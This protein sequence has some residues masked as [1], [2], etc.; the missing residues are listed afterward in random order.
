MSKHASLS[1]AASGER[2]AREAARAKPHAAFRGSANAT[3]ARG[4]SPLAPPSTTS[5]LQIGRTDDVHEREAERAEQAVGTTLSRSAAGL[6]RA[7]ERIQARAEVGAT[8]HAPAGMADRIAA[9]APEGRHLSAEQR[10]FYEQHLGHDF[11]SVRIHA[12]P[13]AAEAASSVRAQAFTH[14]QNVYFGQHH[15]Q[16]A[17][18]AGQRL[19]AHELAH[20]VQQRPN[21]IARR[22][23][24][25]V[26]AREAEPARPRSVDDEPS[27]PADAVA[28]EVDAGLRH[29]PSDASGQA[30][31]RMAQASPAAR[32]KVAAVLQGRLAGEQGPDERQRLPTLKAA[33]PGANAEARAPS[34]TGATRS[35]GPP[36]QHRV[37][38]PEDRAA[39]AGAANARSPAIATTKTAAPTAPAPTPSVTPTAEAG[40]KLEAKAPPSARGDAAAQPA[41]VHAAPSAKSTLQSSSHDGASGGVGGQAAQPSGDDAPLRLADL[42]EQPSR[43]ETANAAAPAAEPMAGG[44]ELRSPAG[45]R[46]ATAPQG[47]AVVAETEPPSEDTAAQMEA[48]AADL[49]AALATTRET[50]KAR[51]AAAGARVRQQAGAARAGIRAQIGRATKQIQADQTGLLSELSTKVGDTHKLIDS[52]LATR[53][54]EAAE[55][56]TT[57]QTTIKGIFKG[58][59]DSVDDTVKTKTKAAETLRDN[60]AETVRQRNKDDM[61][62]AY[63]MARAKSHQYPNTTRGTY[64]GN[65]VYDVAESTVNK[66][67]EQEPEIVQAIKDNTEPL[68]QYFREQ[69]AKAL[70]GFDVNLPKILAS[71]DDGVKRTQGDQDKRA[72]EAHA[73]LN[74]VAAQSKA[75]IAS[76]GLQA[77]AQAAA[78]G[79]QLEAKLD[80][81]L[82]RVLK[83]IKDA[84]DELMRRISP[85]VEEAIGMFRGDGDA[86]VD[87]AKALTVGLKGFVDDSAATSG[88]AMDHAAEASVARFTALHAGAGQVMHA[89]LQKTKKVFDGARSGITTTTG[90]LHGNFDG[91]AAGSVATLK[92]TLTKTETSIRDQLAPVVNQLGGSF[93]ATLRDAEKKID[94]RIAEGLG[95]N[96]EALAETRDKMNEAASE[97]AFEYDHPIRSAIGKGLEFVAGLVVGILAVLAV[98]AVFLLVGWVIATVLGVSMLV[99]GLIM[100]AAVAGFAIGYSFAARLDAGQG[101]GEALLGA[102]GD[103]GRSVPGMLYDM[104]GIPKL[105]K[106]FSDDP[107]TPYERG[108]MLGEGATELVLA[109]FMVRGAAKGIAS[110]FGSLPKFKPPVVAPEI[111]APELTGP[112]G[113]PA[114]SAP[115]EA[116]R[117]GLPGEPVVEP[118]PQVAPQPEPRIGFG[119]EGVR[120]AEPRPPGAPPQPEPRIGFGREPA[121]ASESGAAPASDP[122]IG[123]GRE[124]APEL[125]GAAPKPEPRIGFGREGV[126]AAEPRPADAPPQPEPRIGFGREGVRAAEPRPPGAEP[127]PEPRIGFGREGVRAV[128]PRPPQVEAPAAA[129]SPPVNARGQVYE[130]GRVAGR[131]PV[132]G[133]DQMRPGGRSGMEPS[134]K[135]EGGEAPRPAQPGRVEPAPLEEPRPAQRPAPEQP[136]VEKTAEPGGPGEQAPKQ[137]PAP[138]KQASEPRKPS[139]AKPGAKEPEPAPKQVEPA[140]AKPTEAKSPDSKPAEAKPAEAKP[141]ESKPAESKPAESKPSEGPKPE[142]KAPAEE[143]PDKPNKDPELERRHSELKN[144]VDELKSKRDAAAERWKRLRDQREKADSDATRA[145]KEIGIQEARGKTK[146]ADA[147]RAR[148]KSA[149]ERRAKL[150]QQIS[151]A[152]N[153]TTKWDRAHAKK[154]RELELLE[155][156]LNPEERTSLPCFSAA[157]AV[158]TATGPKPIS[159]LVSGDL[160]RAYDMAA[161]KPELRAIDAVFVNRTV[162]FYDILLAGEIIRATGRHRFWLPDQDRWVEARELRTGERLLHWDGSPKVIEAIDYHDVDVAPTYNLQ[163]DGLSNYFV[164][165]GVLVHNA[166]P[167]NYGFGNNIIYEGTNPDFPGKIYV[168]RTNDRDIREGSHQREAAK[169]LERK[170]LT[171]EERKFWEFKKGMKLKERVSGLTDDQAAFMEQKNI[172]IEVKLNKQNLMNRDLRP[173]S[174]D[175]MKLLEKSI[176]NDPAVQKGGFC[177][178]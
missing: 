111:A 33:P 160:V 133:A 149:L 148:L 156:R 147:E 152:N 12:G 51:S 7:P 137:E 1:L 34:D 30:D 163:V 80:A 116:P 157:T 132:S 153:E 76:L 11:S 172:D 62:S 176:S 146:A 124:P 63:A 71:A 28:D 110:K 120:A 26:D 72:A 79:P 121:P 109:I 98:V 92:Q 88:E 107:M 55:A 119:R 75:D 56:G 145:R 117:L 69:G 141:A 177:P 4:W 78:F 138:K 102:V 58:H 21:V 140:E 151:E 15:Y 159:A 49:E 128:E 35:E 48:L 13:A 29:D 57:S 113:L 126:R 174:Q 161:R 85:P 41:G 52:S 165:P 5:R 81:E 45:A 74:T 129:D 37:D 154:A 68:P 64:I 22:A 19:I 169:N 114:P 90:N 36:R 14:G 59:R 97:A 83:A 73:Q 40:P 65:A 20:T 84:P 3:M 23:L 118:R 96:T 86:D 142:D 24:D 54:R 144:E 101:V 9:A 139:K 99:A 43:D 32:R 123:F 70:D 39:S 47:D 134:A 166:G 18:T 170:D 105:R 106:A 91:A 66:M 61:K 16:P 178:K 115:V 87:A 60:K 46:R 168:G 44:T 50:L 143:A 94:A 82:W 67:R 95:K 93:D 42:F 167:A 108:K 131:E 10:A 112:R 27:Q 135:L 162:H 136:S 17:S 6:S 164:G 125:P 173:V 158:W 38:T 127:Q 89:Q 103:F 8:P 122:H 130:G 2:S 77:I 175:R 171:P 53:K 100:L 150:D 25:G 31:Q 155:L 104:T